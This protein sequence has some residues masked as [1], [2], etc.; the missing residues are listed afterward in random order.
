MSDYLNGFLAIL[1]ERQR[2]RLLAFI[3]TDA[4]N[5]GLS[6]A[7]LE[8]AI[9]DIIGKLAQG[10]SIFVATEH[11]GRMNSAMFNKMMREIY[12]DLFTLYNESNLID[13]LI[14]NTHQ[15]NASILKNI[16]K[17]IAQMERRIDALAIV[18]DYSEGFLSASTD[19]FIDNSRYE[20]HEGNEEMYSDRDGS[21]VGIDKM[22]VVSDGELKLSCRRSED[23]M[24]GAT[25][26]IVE[27]MQ[28]GECMRGD[29]SYTID[30]AID[31]SLES[32]W[33]E[34]ILADEPLKI[35]FPTGMSPTAARVDRGAGCAFKIT[36]PRPAMVSEISLAPYAEYPIELLSIESFTY[37]DD[38]T[39]FTEVRA[40]NPNE[41]MYIDGRISIRFPATI[42]RGLV[43]F[44]RQEHATKNTYLIPKSR[45]VDKQMWRAIAAAE[46]DITLSSPFVGDLNESTSNPQFSKIEESPQSWQ[47][48]V[49]MLKEY[50]EAY[51]ET[52]SVKDAVTAI[53]N[54]AGKKDTLLVDKYEYVYGMY[55][56]HCYGMEYNNVSIYVSK[57]HV[58]TGNVRRIALEAEETHPTF[59]NAAGNIIMRDGSDK[60]LRRTSVEYLATYRDNP[61]AT[62]WYPLLPLGYTDVDCE[63]LMPIDYQH[64]T[65]I[66][67]FPISAESAIA[68]YKDEALLD[69]CDWEINS[70]D[71]RIV[72]IKP[73][74]WSTASIY[75]IDY[76]PDGDYSIVDL[77][78]I[79]KP[80]GK[81]D[82]FP[83]G[84]DRNC[85]VSL[86]HYPYV[87]MQKIRSDITYNP[88]AVTLKGSINGNIGVITQEIK[89]TRNPS[90]ESNPS[91]INARLLN[92]TNY[93][94]DDLPALSPYNPKDSLPT[95]EYCHEGRSVYFTETFGHDGSPAN[96]GVSNGNASISIDYHYLVSNMR[97]KIIL[98][99]TS[100]VDMSIT[101]TVQSYTLK[102]Q[103]LI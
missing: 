89:S 65:V 63:M 8:A 70:D 94:S 3:R 75:T 97:L 61:N 90:A 98:R 13:K 10:Q 96:Y 19:T 33:G 24:H 49:K 72:H 102:F 74:A 43:I 32:F 44:I 50:L 87:D 4:S 99:R 37:Y 54:T 93:R 35:S 80:I 28:I 2:Q 68:I 88:V 30:K 86:S 101:P 22:A 11:T 100:N 77:I 55:D 73:Y 34:V 53:L 21:A 1:P 7:E 12:T 52:K 67:R 81:R 82:V 83:A 31:G 46:T 41:P 45:I 58:A 14:N 40:Y 91:A 42:C 26:S 76:T 29:D 27:G 71:H 92:V 57:P 103:C 20:R 25:I 59:R 48:Y 23:I 15:L 18:A 17:D 47:Q 9:R 95:F 66:A 62:D 69:Q 38:A 64:P 16:E 85:T 36:F 6:E 51:S 84:T 5:E 39:V 78:D 56:V 79:A 60:P